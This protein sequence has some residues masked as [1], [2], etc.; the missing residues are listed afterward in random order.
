[1]QTNHI[2]G[3]FEGPLEKS[4]EMPRYMWLAEGKDNN[5][6]HFKG[7]VSPDYKCMEVISIKSS[8]LGHVA[9]D[10]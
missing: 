6:T 2:M 9:P 4:Q 3:N 5:S 8:L 10:I 7:T 1:V